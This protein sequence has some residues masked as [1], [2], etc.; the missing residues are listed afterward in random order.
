MIQERD[1]RVTSGRS[2]PVTFPSSTTAGNLIVVYLTWDNAGSAFV[3]DSHGHA[4]RSAVG[5]TRWNGGRYSAQIFYTDVRRG[6]VITVT[7][8]FA[9]AV[10]SFGIVYAHEYSGLLSAAPVDVTAAA[11]GTSGSLNSGSATSTNDID[12]IFAGGVSARHLTSPGAGYTARATSYGSLT[13]DKTVFVKGSY[14]A[15]ANNSGGAWAMQMVAFKATTG[16]TMDITAPTMPTGVS[17]SAL[18]SS[19]I[20]LSWTAS[21]DPDNLPGQLTYGVYRNGTRIATTG[22]GVTSLTDSGLAASTTYSYTIAALDPAGNASAQTAPIPATTLSLDTQ[23]PTVSITSPTNNQVVSGTV[24]VSANATDNV[25]VLGVQF[26]LDG[27]SLGAEIAASPYVTTWNSDQATNGSHLLTAIARDAAGNQTVSSVVTVVVSNVSPKSY[28]TG[29]PSIENPISE[30]GHWV[31]GK[32]V[33]LDWGD[34][35]TTSGFAFGTNSGGYADPTAILAGSWGPDQMAQAVVRCSNPSDS[36]A[37][38]VELRLRSAISAHSNAGYEINFLCSKTGNGYSQVVRWN[39]PLA[40]FTYLSDNSGGV[41]TGDVVLARMVGN[42]ITVYI[43]G[44]QIARVTDSTFATGSPGMGFYL[45]GGTTQN[46]DFGFTSFTGSEIST[47]GPTPSPTPANLSTTSPRVSR[48]DPRRD[49]S[50]DVAVAR[51]QVFRDN[52]QPTTAAKTGWSDNSVIPGVQYVSA[53]ASSCPLTSTTC[54]SPHVW[55]D[56]EDPRRHQR[57][58]WKPR[59]LTAAP[60]ELGPTQCSGRHAR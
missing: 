20:F 54:S 35:R 53:V 6:G 10:T 7:A 51:Y 17:A 15:T 46:A 14:D 43:N 44:T 24:T 52:N 50:A 40:N 23:A 13:E 55:H 34:V 29:F 56:V 5:P 4:Y 39:G 25:G 37:E 27:G 47:T 21:T 45:D 59:F 1:N 2:C 16:G 8:T 11:S 48:V 12:L 19:Q 58:Q 36:L 38:E 28:T 9:T 32:S 42:V 49:A 41:V 33:G 31:N 3:S 26:R 57:R 60:C 22:S 18:S 30:G